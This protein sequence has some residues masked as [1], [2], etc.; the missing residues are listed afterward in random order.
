MSSDNKSESKDPVY[1]KFIAFS[2]FGDK[3]SAGQME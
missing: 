1:E 2:G 3:T